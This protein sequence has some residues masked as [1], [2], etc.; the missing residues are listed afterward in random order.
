MN[1][2]FTVIFAV[3]C[4]SF[5]ACGEEVAYESAY[6]NSQSAWLTAK[7]S[8]GNAYVYRVEATAA[9]GSG[10]ATSLLVREDAVIQRTF[11]R[12][13]DLDFR[14]GLLT[15]WTEEQSEIGAHDEGAAPL[16]VD[17]L[18]EACHGSV[19]NKGEG[20]QIA[21]EVDSRGILKTCT[22][23]ASGCAEDA[24]TKG[25]RINEVIFMTEMG[26]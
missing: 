15:E 12:Y 16:T 26:S 9:D 22:Y 24:C 3:S 21:F 13:E 23:R 18:Y 25:V 5:T 7:V 4:F 1:K 17:D 19:L 11:K 20:Y 2:M 6:I 14:M 10:Q 8:N